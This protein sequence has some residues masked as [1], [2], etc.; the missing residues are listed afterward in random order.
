MGGTTALLLNVGAA[1]GWEHRSVRCT[2]SGC[3]GPLTASPCPPSLPILLLQITHRSSEVIKRT[4]LLNGIQDS[5][6][7]QLKGKK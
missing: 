6:D 1:V 5:S 3:A 2:Q 7:L 4:E